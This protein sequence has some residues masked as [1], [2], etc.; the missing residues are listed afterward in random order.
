VPFPGLNLDLPCL[1]DF[2]VVLSPD[3]RKLDEISMFEAFANSSDP[4]FAIRLS[5]DTAAA[6]TSFGEY[7]H[8]NSARVIDER[9]ARQF[10]FA[11]AGQ[12]CISMPHY[13]SF[14]ALLD[15]AERRFVWVTGGAWRYQH[16][17]DFL[18][19]GHILLFDNC[20]NQGPGGFSRVLEIDPQSGGTVWSYR[21]TTNDILQ[22][23]K[24]SGQQR[25]PNGNTLITESDAGRLL[26]VTVR[27]D[28]VWEFVNPV[29]AGKNHQLIPIISTGER[30]APESLAPSFRDYLGSKH[31]QQEKTP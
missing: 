31:P 20:G 16:D 3:G 5:Q 25:L 21:G 14:L 7:L 6:K 17:P 11:R 29:R 19:N 1:E 22:S 13:E 28:V 4:R 10:P 8:C 12:V 18:E 27:G 23:G 24:R 2:L 9:T 26:E 30:I 15:P